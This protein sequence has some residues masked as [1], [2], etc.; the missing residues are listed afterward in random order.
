MI[1]LLFSVMS[2]IERIRYGDDR[3]FRDFIDHLRKNGSPSEPFVDFLTNKQA[4]ALACEFGRTEIVNL[5][6]DYADEIGEYVIQEGYGYPLREACRC[7]GNVDVVRRLIQH[8]RDHGQTLPLDNRYGAFEESP[9]TVASLW[10]KIE[11][12][13]E[14]LSYA[15]ETGQ[16]LDKL[17]KVVVADSHTPFSAACEGASTTSLDCV[18]LLADYAYEHDIYINFRKNAR[19]LMLVQYQD[20]WDPEIQAYLDEQVQIS[21]M[22][23]H[24]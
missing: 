5:F 17:D 8:A 16:S 4:L 13:Q 12:L 10:G 14:F 20:T 11:I 23:K 1:D 19:L 15:E 7:F 22:Q 3:I 6:L 21:E 18:K 24:A 9:M 2:L